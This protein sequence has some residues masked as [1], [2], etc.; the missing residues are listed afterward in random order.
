MDGARPRALGG[1]ARGETVERRRTVRAGI[2]GPAPGGSRPP[3]AVPTAESGIGGGPGRGGRCL[4][5][6]PHR[7][8]A[9]DG[10]DALAADL[11]PDDRPR[12]QGEPAERRGHDIDLDDRSAH[13]YVAPLQGHGTGP[14]RLERQ[15]RGL[16]LPAQAGWLPVTTPWPRAMPPL[17][18]NKTSQIFVVSPADNANALAIASFPGSAVVGRE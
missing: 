1:L 10:S 6:G 13:H 3:S 9:H 8:C 4:R 11:R 16:V 12:D 15:P 7:Q 17:K 2:G 5:P 14:Q 18:S